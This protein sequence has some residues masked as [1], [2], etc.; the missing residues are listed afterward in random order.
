MLSELTS[1][2]TNLRLPERDR[3][4]IPDP[5][6]DT[7]EDFAETVTPAIVETANAVVAPTVT[8]AS[9][10]QLPPAGSSVPNTATTLLQDELKLGR[11]TDPSFLM[12]MQE[13]LAQ[14]YWADA[15]CEG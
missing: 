4:Y 9:L 12:K 8:E 13:I 6:E 15:I 3:F 10:H 14:L 2:Q 1:N 5:W 11:K 7:T